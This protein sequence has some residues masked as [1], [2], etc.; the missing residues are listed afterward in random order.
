MP[1]REQQA[2]AARALPLLDLTDLSDNCRAIAV[3]ALCRRAVTPHG[4]VAAI[5]IWPRFV[6]D[7]VRRLAGT[8]IKIAT[9][10]NFPHGED[11]L[12]RA[13][14]DCRETLRDGADEI[15]L[16]M[17]YQAFLA[18]NISAAGDLIGAV[19]DEIPHGKTLKVILE[20]G[21]LK[22]PDKIAAA[23]ELAIAKGA[24]FLKTSTGKIAVSATPEAAQTM[25]SVIQKHGRTV[26]F[27]AAGG[28]RQI[29]D[30]QA[31][32]ELADRMMGAAWVNARHFR[33]G[34]SGLLDALLARLDGRTD[35]TEGQY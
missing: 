11:E 20:T 13:V 22:T 19:A 1:D 28:I 27:K 23:S 32:L 18:G 8:G 2:I 16:V 24:N 3:D 33:L 35:R 9:V 34:A 4:T 12:E 15:D 17:P 26:G 7:A 25:L 10:V 14:S 29:A 21:A 30:A 31:Y 6:P 5:C